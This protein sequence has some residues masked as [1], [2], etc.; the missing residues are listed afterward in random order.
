MYPMTTIASFP[1]TSLFAADIKL[2]H[3][4]PTHSRTI[5]KF[6]CTKIRPDL[7]TNAP[8]HTTAKGERSA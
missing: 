7:Q 3:S 5:P 8:S 2:S 4:Q 6:H 1:L